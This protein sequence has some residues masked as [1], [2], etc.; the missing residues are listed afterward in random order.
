MSTMW[1]FDGIEHEHGVCIGEDYIKKFCESLREHTTI[2]E[3]EKKVSYTIN[4][5]RI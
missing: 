2:I 4:K 1:T 5:L 3:F